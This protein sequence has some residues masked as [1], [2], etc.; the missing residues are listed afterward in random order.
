MRVTLTLDNGCFLKP[1]QSYREVGCYQRADPVSDLRVYVDGEEME[2]SRLL[3]LGSGNALVE[4]RH[5]TASGE[6]HRN[7]ALESSNLAACLASL[8]ELYGQDVDVDRDRFDCVLRIESGHLRP[9][10]L[11]A[12]AFMET[13]QRPDG[14][15]KPTGKWKELDSVAHEVVVHFDL[16]SGDNWELISDGT[17]VLSV[18]DLAARLS[19]DINL[20]AD[21]ETGV[22]IYR[23]AFA[24]ERRNYWF[25]VGCD[26]GPSGP[27]PPCRAG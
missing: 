13:E 22:R 10:I 2:G 12:R 20:A 3:K 6:V 23:D 21:D 7:R 25:P 1:T 24:H 18:K 5:T 27:F 8:N 19:V 17:T 14:I 16:S 26:V 11:R 4:L 9:S 15:M